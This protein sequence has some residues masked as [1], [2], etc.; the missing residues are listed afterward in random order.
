[1]CLGYLY[2]SVID[3]VQEVNISADGCYGKIGTDGEQGFPDF[4]L[5]CRNNLI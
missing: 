4:L 3:C 1:M 2:T 5:Y